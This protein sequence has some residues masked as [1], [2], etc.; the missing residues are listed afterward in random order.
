[1]PVKHLMY[2]LSAINTKSV[3]FAPLR[4][5][6][7]SIKYLVN[8]FVNIVFF[9]ISCNSF[10]YLFSYLFIYIIIYLFIYLFIY[11][12]IYFDTA[13]ILLSKSVFCVVNFLALVL[14]E[15]FLL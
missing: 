4:I 12:Y 1:M 2:F 3:S 7:L 6:N 8:P 13:F 9:D 5:L 14:N 15:K 10:I 11:L